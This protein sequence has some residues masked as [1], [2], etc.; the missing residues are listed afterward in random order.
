MKFVLLRWLLL[1]SVMFVIIAVPIYITLSTQFPTD[2]ELVDFFERNKTG[3][4]QLRQ[5]LSREPA[6]IRGFSATEVLLSEGVGN[7]VSPNRAGVAPS[8]FQEI[9]HQMQEHEVNFLWRQE[10]MTLI[11]AGFSGWGSATKGPRLCYVH[12]LHSPTHQV[13]NLQEIGDE[14]YQLKEQDWHMVY[15]PLGDNWYIRLIW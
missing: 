9:Q 10:G 13:T 15:K 1:G 14:K 7:W 6:R 11:R 4:H 8:R 2:E 3:F 12:T 5:E